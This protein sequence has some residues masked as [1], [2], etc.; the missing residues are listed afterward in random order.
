MLFK[1]LKAQ[2]YNL[3]LVKVVSFKAVQVKLG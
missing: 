1:V 3:S 2:A